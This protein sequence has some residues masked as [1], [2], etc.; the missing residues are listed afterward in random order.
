MKLKYSVAAALSVIAWFACS[1]AKNSSGNRVE[2]E[3]NAAE[4]RINVLIGGK[5]FTAYQWPDSIFKPVLYPVINS[6]GTEVTRGYPLNPRPNE[7]VDHP[8]HVGVWLNYGNV[9]G[10]DFWGNSY[11]IPEDARKKTGGTI[12]HVK[13][14]DIS[15][16][17]GSASMTTYSSW[18]DPAGKELLSEKTSFEFIEKDS[19]RIIDRNTML[20]ATSGDVSMPDTKEG[21]YAIRVARQLE[22]PSKEEVV[23]TDASN[24]PTTV[25]QLSN[26]GVTGNYRSSE[27]ITGEDV[28]STRARWMN[29]AGDINGEKVSVVICDHP[30]NPSYPSY[31]HARGY[32]LF[33]VNP[34]GAK[35]FTKEKESVN[36]VIPSGQSVNFRYRLIISSGKQLTDDEINELANDF[37]K[38]Y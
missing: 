27:G 30:K 7:R 36:F 20:T 25:P 15:S 34:L 17:N 21:M 12:R 10:I 11:D 18:Q 37:G 4:K 22:L 3:Q 19:L 9:N 23:L 1:T 35:D 32:G 31:W 2:I 14:E 8:H 26:E 16:G 6:A 28:W 5:L 13:V 38:K 24:R 33:S 29:L